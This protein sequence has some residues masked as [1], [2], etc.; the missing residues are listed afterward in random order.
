MLL[1]SDH[2]EPGKESQRDADE[3]LIRKWPAEEDQ[4]RPK[5]EQLGRVDGGDVIR[6]VAED[7]ATIDQDE[8][9]EGGDQGEEWMQNPDDIGQ[10]LW[11]G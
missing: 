1:V 4:V 2:R 5:I 10:A 11:L 8:R 3:V 7:N 6:L 9:A